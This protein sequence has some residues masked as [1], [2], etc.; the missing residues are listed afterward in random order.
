M[1]YVIKVWLFTIVFSPLPLATIF[2]FSQLNTDSVNFFSFEIVLTT[3]VVGLIF[4][5]PAMVLF[6][7][8]KKILKSRFSILKMKTVL[9]IYSFISVWVTFYLVDI[10]FINGRTRQIIGVWVY[11]FSIVLGVWI[12]KSFDIKKNEK[13][14]STVD[15]SK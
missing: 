7:I 2:G 13:Q 4:S 5:L 11:S 6:A 1:R 15:Q 12:F 9:S 14:M 10:G 3:I 8:I